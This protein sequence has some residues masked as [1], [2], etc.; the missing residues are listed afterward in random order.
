VCKR[1]RV[2]ERE[3]ERERGREREEGSM[4]EDRGSYK[5]FFWPDHYYFSY[6]LEM[7][8]VAGT[9]RVLILGDFSV[10]NKS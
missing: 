5:D 7:G 10:L 9:R 8:I 6:R 3:K 4:S 1:E 2:R